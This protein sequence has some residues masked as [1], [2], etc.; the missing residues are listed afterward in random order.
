MIYIAMTCKRL[1][2]Q[3][4]SIGF[5]LCEF[6]QYKNTMYGIFLYLG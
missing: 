5:L 2:F 3:Y 6:F 1:L 4:L